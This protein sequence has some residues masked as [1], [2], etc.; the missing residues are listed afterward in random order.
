MLTKLHEWHVRSGARMIDFNGWDMPIQYP[1]GPREEHL[2][3][4]SAAGLF[5]IDHMGRFEISGPDSLA[6]LQKAQTWDVSRLDEGRAHYSLLCSE[7]GGII[8]DIFLYHLPDSWLI[9]VNAANTTKDLAWLESLTRGLKVTLRDRGSD[10]CL[11][12]LQGPAALEI[13][14]PLCGDMDV[15]ELGFHRVRVCSIVGSPSILCTAGYTGEPGCEMLVPAA[16]SE[17]IWTAVLTAGEARGLLPCGLGARD[18]LRAEA[19][20]PLYGREIDE[21]T[22][23]FSAGL[24]RAAVSM[25]GH[26]FVGKPALAAIASR[27]LPHRLVGFEMVD[28]GIPRQGYAIQAGGMKVGTVTTGL[29]SPS[30]GRF[31]GMGYVEAA[32]AGIGCE[33]QIVI[34]DSS[35]AAR[36]VKR[37]F[38]TSPHWR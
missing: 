1:T 24:A 38:Y 26:D 12:A 10:T 22:D 4:R 36:V 30:T 19:C 25:D 2:R 3:V 8:D 5:D 35:K 37:P 9:I 13:I 29:A 17:R 33:V 7:S 16:D 23:P 15:D 31:L 21:S 28:A 32:F 27:P 34:R 6:L 11:L 18:S 20:L 14:K